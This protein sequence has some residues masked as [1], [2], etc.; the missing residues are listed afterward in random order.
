MLSAGVVHSMP[1]GV[2]GV[3]FFIVFRNKPNNHVKLFTQNIF[4]FISLIIYYKVENVVIVL[5]VRRLLTP[6]E[7][8]YPH[9]IGCWGSTKWSL[10]IPVRLLV[11]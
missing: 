7:G 10:K 4:Y 8:G 3:Q 9:K 6:Q 2:Q 1:R 5:I 11:E